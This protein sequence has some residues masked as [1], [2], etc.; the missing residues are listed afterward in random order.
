MS[1]SALFGG[2]AGTMPMFDSSPAC[3]LGL[4][5]WFPGR[6]GAGWLRTLARSLGSRTCSFSARVWLSDY[7]GSSGTRAFAP[8]GIAYPLRPHGRHPEF[9]FRSSIPRSPMPLSTLHRRLTAPG[10]RLKVKMVRYSF[11]VGLFHPLLHAG[12]SRRFRSLTLPAPCQVRIGS[13]YCLANEFC[14]RDLEHAAMCGFLWR[15]DLLCLR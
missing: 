6:S 13:E 2:F 15:P 3:V 1:P 7:A 14:D 9:V 11:L 10:A 8:F 12:L 5:L 4:C